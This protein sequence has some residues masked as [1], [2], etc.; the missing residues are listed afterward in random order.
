MHLDPVFPYFYSTIRSG[1]SFLYS[2]ENKTRENAHVIFSFPPPLASDNKESTF[3]F[4]FLSLALCLW[5]RWGRWKA[6]KTQRIRGY[7]FFFVNNCCATD[8]VP[9]SPAACWQ[10]AVSAKISLVFP[11]ALKSWWVEYKAE[12]K[13]PALDSTQLLFKLKHFFSFPLTPGVL[14][15]WCLLIHSSFL[16][17]D[18]EFSRN[19]FFLPIEIY[20]CTQNRGYL[21]NPFIKP[22]FTFEK[23]TLFSSI[24]STLRHCEDTVVDQCLINPLFLQ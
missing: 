13:L 3:W 1:T 14:L 12:Y 16:V 5:R 17:E 20:H 21:I 9:W 19:H 15:Q 24:Y 4:I 7:L 11:E 10:T 23:G 6:T 22:V 8:W 2:L 18:A